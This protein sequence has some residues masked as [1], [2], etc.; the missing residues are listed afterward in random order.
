LTGGASDAQRLQEDARW[1]LSLALLKNKEPEKAKPHLRQL[2]QDNGLHNTEAARLLEQI[3]N[4][5]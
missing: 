4:A 2:I 5:P 1:Y 3:N